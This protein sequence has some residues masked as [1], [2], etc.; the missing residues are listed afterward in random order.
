M[1][2]WPVLALLLAGCPRPPPPAQIPQRAGPV[3]CEESPETTWSELDLADAG[4]QLS[5]EGDAGTF[6]AGVT[7][8]GTP[9]AGAPSPAGNEPPKP[10]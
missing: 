10:Q 4:L 5:I 2:R 9:D 1:R 8:G 6:G 7:D 3:V